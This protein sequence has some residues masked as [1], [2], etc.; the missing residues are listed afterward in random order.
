MT[1]IVQ[2]KQALLEWINSS[3]AFKCQNIEM[4]FGDASFRRYFRF[5]DEVS[6]TS[7]IAVDAPPE[8]EDS[9]KFVNLANAYFQHQVIVPKVLAHD[10]KRGFYCLQDFGDMQF[11]QGLNLDSMHPLYTQALN[12]IPAIQ[13]CTVTNGQPLPLY[14]NE[15]LGKEKYIFTHWLIEVHLNIKLTKNQQDTVDKCYEFLHQT[16]KSQ[17]QVGVHRDFHSRN[18]MLLDN[19]DI[20][21]IDFQDAVIGPITYDAV[22]LLRDCYQ[23]WPRELV[24][25]LLRE[26]HQRFYGQYQWQD[27][28]RWFDLTGLQRHLKASGIFC[29][30]FHRDGKNDY[31]THIPRTLEYILE[32]GSQYAELTDLVALIENTIKPKLLELSK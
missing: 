18:L 10:P 2:I 22:S 6:H 19:G 7:I 4:I 27:F 13:S 14:D 1:Q 20:G 24:D 25:S 21:V 32:V 11:S 26:F 16:F 12:Q 23:K 3:T 31:L 30:L 17:P 15:L 8:F 5:W 9:S 28:S 29:R